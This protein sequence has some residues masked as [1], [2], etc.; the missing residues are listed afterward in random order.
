MRGIVLSILVLFSSS[1]A[2]AIDHQ[3]EIEQAQNWVNSF[4]RE[5]PII[6]I[7]R[8][9]TNFLLQANNA[10][11][12]AEKSYEVIKEYFDEAADIELSFQDY[13][14]LENYITKQTNTAISIPITKT[15]GGEYEFC[16]VFANA[17]NGNSQ[18]ETNRLMGFDQPDVYLDYPNYNYDNL[19]ET[20]SFEELYL[21]SLYHEASHCLDV[22][23]IMEMQ[24]YGG[25]P[26]GIHQA[27]IY[28]E[29]LAYLVLLP[30]LG[31]EVASKRALYRFVYSRIVG[32]FLTTVPTLG[33]PN[34][35]S[36]G[37]IYNL[38]PYLYK[39]L[40]LIQFQ[41]IDLERPLDL[42]ARDFV[43]EHGMTSREFQSIV[44][45]LNQGSEQALSQ[46]K[47]WAFKDPHYFYSAYMQLIQY[48][49]YT[50][51][52][53]D[54]AF[55]VRPEPYYDKAPDL[56]SNL[57]CRSVENNDIDEYFELLK[58]YRMLIN[59][60]HFEINSI[61]QVY[62]TLNSLDINCN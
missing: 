14:S 29:I 15:F 56:Y 45:Y 52:L 23:F 12:N 1:Y 33:D 10:K 11:G 54:Y 5:Y 50:T 38:G 25:E 57:L 47:E 42:V 27:E 18:V 9:K 41:Q 61:N 53:L 39:M 8:D 17:P 51:D 13:R 36:G 4:N 49:Q 2:Q 44:M 34:I 7:D 46:Y 19:N 60:K 28:A 16:A 6:V 26:H 35:R 22:D 59:N 30:R 58:E 31:K 24:S 62:K 32:E 37:A 3:I 21:F 48:K 40:E 55:T 20:M 43:L